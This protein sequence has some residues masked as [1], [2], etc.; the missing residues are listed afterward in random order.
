MRCIELYINEDG[1]FR[2]SESM[3]E[4]PEQYEGQEGEGEGQ[5]A[6]T[7]EEAL[8]LVKQMAMSDSKEQE[9]TAMD[10][11]MAGYNKQKRPEMRAP[12]P[13]AVFGEG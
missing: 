4:E 12:N 5:Q 7:I 2:V 3:K 10:Q 11:A 9:Q 13:E 6:A 8:M 1:T